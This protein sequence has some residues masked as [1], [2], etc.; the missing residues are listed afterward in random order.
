M[1]SNINDLQKSLSTTS[2]IDK[3]ADKMLIGIDSPVQKYLTYLNRH[4]E[5]IRK[6]TQPF[7]AFEM[8]KSHYENS[9]GNACRTIQAAIKDHEKLFMGVTATSAFNSIIGM[10]ENQWATIQQSIVHDSTQSFHSQHESLLFG[11]AFN[12]IQAAIKANEKIFLGVK[13]A[14]NLDA[15]LST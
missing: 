1:K 9:L 11:N 6:A 12:T 15:A 7:S 14:S 5:V 2:L 13:T 4:Q 8:T 3:M 10:N